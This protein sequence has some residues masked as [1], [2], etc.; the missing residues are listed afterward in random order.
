MKLKFSSSPTC[1]TLRLEERLSWWERAAAEE[2]EG[3]QLGGQ[4]EERT[5]AISTT[6]GTGELTGGGV[7]PLELHRDVVLRIDMNYGTQSS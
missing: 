3:G 6:W 5:E 7:L 1:E 2:G 4:E